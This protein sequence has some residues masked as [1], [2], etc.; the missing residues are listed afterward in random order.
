MGWYK[1][2]GNRYE[3]LMMRK[4]GAGTFAACINMEA[5]PSVVCNGSAEGLL[6]GHVSTNP[7]FWVASNGNI[8]TISG[9]AFGPWIG[10]SGTPNALLGT[11]GS[12]HFIWLT[13]GS[14]GIGTMTSISTTAPVT[15]CSSPCTGTATIGLSVTTTNDGGA[16]VNQATTPGTAQ[17]GNL[18]L[19]GTVK[20]SAFVGALTGNVTGNLAGVADTAKA[21]KT[22]GADVDVSGSSA[23]GGAGYTLLT[24]NATHATWQVAATGTL[25]S[26]VVSPPLTGGTITTTGS[27]GC[28]TMGASGGSH[29]PG[30]TPD[31]SATPGTAK[32]L[33]EDAPWTVPSGSDPTTTKGDLFTHDATVAAR[34]AVGTDTYILTADSTQATGI[35]WA[36]ATSVTGTTAGQQD[37]FTGDGV[38]TVFVLS[39]SPVANGIIYVSLNGLPQPTTAWSASG[40]NITM[41]AAP[42]SGALLAV[43]YFTALPGSVTHIQ[44]DFAGA[45]STDFTLS[46]TP[47]VGGGV[48]VVAL[49]G[50]IQPQTSWS[51]VSSTTLR[52]SSADPTGDEVTISYNY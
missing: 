52:F 7:G 23:P 37:Q 32:F 3:G 8:M 45:G 50:L 12:G 5:H 4:S 31:T 1:T 51:I 25:T 13:A 14:G 22:S 10:M 39:G 15:G 43:G 36:A 30:C 21:L 26:I 19:T 38:T 6:V 49:R 47:A 28:A 41:V 46:H 18:N 33:R 40:S 44:Q 27:I 2:S 9:N 11:D 17:T 16:V 42:I 34:L 35:K 20:A 48:I 24:T 29:A